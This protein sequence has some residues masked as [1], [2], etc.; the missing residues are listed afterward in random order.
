MAAVGRVHGVLDTFL[1]W[2]GLV[3]YSI[4]LLHPALIEVYTSVPWTQ[5]ENFL[6]MEL[7]MVALFVLAL[8][9]VCALT[10]R[11][12]EAPMQRRGKALA[13]RLDARFG[14]DT[15][16]AKRNVYAGQSR[17]PSSLM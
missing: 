5:D 13:R 2:L 9:V 14:E 1:A 16:L 10:Y 7:L 8:L 3:S 12:I 15:H 17:F 4:Y 11:F 6:P